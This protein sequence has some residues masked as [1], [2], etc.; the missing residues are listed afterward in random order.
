MR[1]LFTTF[2]IIA[3]LFSCGLTAQE[4]SYDETTLTAEPTS[5]SSAASE[6]L[7][8]VAA[9]LRLTEDQL[10]QVEAILLEFAAQP[11]PTTPEARKARRRALRARVSQ[12]LTP[13]QLALARQ[14]RQ[15]KGKSRQQPT[16]QKRNLLDM[17]IEDVATPFIEQ[18][19]KGKNGPN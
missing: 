11:A 17:L 9:K 5:L 12:L 7:K 14:I 19:L 10:P 13:E 2:F 3:S 4:E 1:L 15:G 8:K 6:K 18:R 16:T